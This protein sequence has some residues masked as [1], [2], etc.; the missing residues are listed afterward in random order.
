[1]TDTRTHAREEKKLSERTCADC[2][3]LLTAFEAHVCRRCERKNSYWADYG[4]WDLTPE[5]E[6]AAECAY[7]NSKARA[8]WDH[9]HP[10][11]PCPDAELPHPKN[12]T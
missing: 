2:D 7:E 9:Y 6:A 11:E 5:E 10:G 4:D 8:E 1:M 12:S 3:D